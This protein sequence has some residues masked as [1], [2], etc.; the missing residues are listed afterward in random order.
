[1]TARSDFDDQEW[2]QISEAPVTAGMIVLTAEHGGTF[3][4][5]WALSHAYVDARKQH[6]QSELLDDIAGGKPKFDRHKFHSEQ[7]LRDGGLKLV[8]DAAATIDKKA[9]PEEADAY[10]K[11]VLQ[12]AQ[13]VAEAHKEHGQQISPGEQAALDEVRKSL[14][15]AAAS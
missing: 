1:M 8:S 13:R 4:E 14:E 5:T 12:V 10:R 2:E 6:G 7:E 11:F 15:A 9:T 3:R